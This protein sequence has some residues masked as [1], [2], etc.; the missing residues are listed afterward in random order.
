MNLLIHSMPLWL[1]LVSLV[2]CIGG[3]AC[4]LWI[5][6]ARER[7]DVHNADLT[8]LRLWFFLRLSVFAAIAGSCIDLLIRT[9]EMSGDPILS[10]LPYLTTVLFKTHIGQVWLIRMITY[11]IMSLMM[12]AGNKYRDSPGYLIALFCL[13]VL[14]AMMESASGHASDKG[15]FSMAEIMDWIHLL[16][17]SVWGGGLFALALT[18]HPV[19]LEAGGHAELSIVE[20]ASRFSR[21][22]G[23]AV[24]T[25]AATAVYN[26][27]VYVGSYEAVVKSSY[28]WTIV[29]K[30]IL[31][32]ILLLLGAINRYISVPGMREWSGLPPGNQGIGSRLVKPL[33]RPFTLNQEDRASLR[34]FALRI[35]I[36]AFLMVAVLLCASLLR[37]E[38]PAKHYLHQHNEHHEHHHTQ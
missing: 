27:W 11:I 31:F 5:L 14:A 28:G 13:G 12:T 26:A 15:D 9:A 34:Q 2:F 19:S 10:A 35:R 29:V 22:A 23:I 25:I 38:V 4:L 36:E 18:L 33:L 20:T 37:H 8:R 32:L 30:S 21:I 7:E 17:A 16:A 3:L 1:E 24:A 6:P